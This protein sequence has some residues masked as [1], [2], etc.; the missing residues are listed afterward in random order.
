MENITEIDTA[1]NLFNSSGGQF[2]FRIDDIVFI[3]NHTGTYVYSY[4]LKH[5]QYTS[6]STNF[7]WPLKLVVP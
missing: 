2:V 3:P 5:I 7:S 6:Y 4:V 1:T